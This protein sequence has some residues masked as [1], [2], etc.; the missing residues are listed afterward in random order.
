M[1]AHLTPVHLEAYPQLNIF[2]VQ[3]AW[4]RR[5]PL[6]Q[7]TELP[8]KAV[9]QLLIIGLSP[10]QLE[11]V[12]TGLHSIP[13]VTRAGAVFD[14]VPAPNGVDRSRVYLACPGCGN[15]KAA[16]FLRGS[17]KCA[18][19]HH[20]RYRDQVLDKLVRKW[21]Q[22]RQLEALLKN[23]RP[24]RMRHQ[25]YRQLLAR[26]DELKRMPAHSEAHANAR[27][28]QLVARSWLRPS[29]AGDSLASDYVFESGCYVL[30]PLPTEKP[31]PE[32]APQQTVQIVS[33][34]PLF[35]DEDFPDEW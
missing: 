34:S 13:V 11:V 16:L 31:K 1:T 14:L 21:E 24:P 18:G 20:L 6:C 4:R 33:A 22:R 17:W 30:R 8:R 28:S 23:G 9:G 27:Q 25:R 2:E 32:H 29:D 7:L 19:C 26:F 35:D 10:S 15:R 5:A 12:Y 3:R